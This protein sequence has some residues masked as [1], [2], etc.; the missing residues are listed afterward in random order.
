MMGRE[1]C[2]LTHVS[3]TMAGSEGMESGEDVGEG[4]GSEEGRRDFA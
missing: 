2:V 4:E 3:L 1:S